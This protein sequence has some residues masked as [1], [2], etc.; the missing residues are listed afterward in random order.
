M[1]LFNVGNYDLILS[2]PP[3]KIALYQFPFIG[4]DQSGHYSVSPTPTAL[5]TQALT[6]PADSLPG[7]AQ[8]CLLVS[9]AFELFSHTYLRLVKALGRASCP[10]PKLGTEHLVRHRSKNTQPNCSKNGVT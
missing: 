2:P 8:A 7:R 4:R 5:Q 3:K 10:K 1:V 6:Q 9:L